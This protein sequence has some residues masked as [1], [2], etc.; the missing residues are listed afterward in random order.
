MV[1]IV[2]IIMEQKSMLHLVDCTVE[3]ETIQVVPINLETGQVTILNSEHP[4][5]PNTGSSG[6]KQ[7]EVFGLLLILSVAIGGWVKMQ[8][9]R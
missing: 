8:R 2:P 3:A 1:M 7:Y 5:L 9:Q 6:T 4:K